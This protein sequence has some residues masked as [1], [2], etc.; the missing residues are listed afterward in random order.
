VSPATGGGFA[1]SGARPLG[2]LLVHGLTATA[3]EMRPLGEALAARGFPVRAPCLAGHGTDLAGLARTGWADWFASVSDGLAR[4][5]AEVPRVAVVGMSLG[6]LL[7][8]HLAATRPTMVEGLVLCGTPIRLD[9]T[10]IRLLPILARLPFV[11]R[12]YATIPKANGKPDIADPAMRAASQSYAAVPLVAVLELLRLQ[13]LVWR[14]LPS[15]TQPALLLHG[16]HDHSVPVT[17][18]EV[19]RSRLGSR[20]I[21]THVLERSWH[22]ITLDY[23]RDQVAALTAAF[24]E[25]LETRIAVGD[26]PA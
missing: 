25:R 13:A 19:L 11:A 3:E 1:L 10:R 4:L 17:N 5:H 15:V 7:G 18:L 26:R 24:L 22:V 8:L 14:E 20:S 21:E 6:G 16:R 23:D 12:R 2:C 9:G